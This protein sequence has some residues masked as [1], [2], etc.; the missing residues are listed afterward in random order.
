M[1]T[2]KHI[3][4]VDDDEAF[5]YLLQREFEGAGW[6]TTVF[7]DWTGV[8]EYFE[9]G[10]PANLLLADLRLPSGTP[11]GVSLARMAAKRRGA[12]KIAFITAHEDLSLA[13]PADL[14]PVLSKETPLA[15]ILAAAEGMTA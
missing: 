2:A 7:T 4:I 9:A 3:V 1:S 10:E 12:L 15:D 13:V 5:R 6:T 11:N 8:L 14:G